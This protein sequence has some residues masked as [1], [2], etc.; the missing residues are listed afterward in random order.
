VI[1]VPG[2]IAS[3]LVRGI[4]GEGDCSTTTRSST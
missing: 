4:G 2:L 3:V 1:I